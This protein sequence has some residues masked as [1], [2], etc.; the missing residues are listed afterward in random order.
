[1]GVV[2]QEPSDP[3]QGSFQSRRG[4]GLLLVAPAE[5][6]SH[7]DAEKPPSPVLSS[8][9]SQPREPRLTPGPAL[10]SRRVCALGVPRGPVA[11]SFVQRVYQPFLTTCGGHRVCSTYR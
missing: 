8:L 3:P 11:E 7:G 4:L 10:C 9:G 1:M 6:P 2:G 5:G